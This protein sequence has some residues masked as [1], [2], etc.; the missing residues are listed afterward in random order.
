MRTIR[1]LFVLCL[2][3][4]ACGVSALAQD[5][6]CSAVVPPD[7]AGQLLRQAFKSM[8]TAPDEQA[9]ITRA[10]EKMKGGVASLFCAEPVDLD[11]DGKQDL[12]IHQADVEGAFCTAHNCP[13][14]VYH[15]TGSGYRMLLEDTGGYLSPVAALKTST[16][17]YRD[18]QTTQQSS[19]V[20]H[21]ITVFKFDGH[22]YRA[23][24]CTTEKYAGKRRGKDRF[25]YI[26]HKCG[27]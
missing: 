22:K 2:L 19:A 11:G 6:G 14:W 8:E 3:F 25:T 17:G 16:N 13:V 10:A 27:Q 20:E 9:N 23:R 18:I 12:L 1:K 21:E 26:T 5:K 7:L 4:A 15:R 24:V